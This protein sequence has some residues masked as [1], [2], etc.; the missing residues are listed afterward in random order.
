MRGF[1]YHI[2]CQTHLLLV[3]QRLSS[4]FENVQGSVLGQLRG[5]F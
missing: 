3:G 4:E 5:V 2:L 1:Q